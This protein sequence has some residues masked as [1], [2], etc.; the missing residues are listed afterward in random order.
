MTAKKIAKP[1]VKKTVPV[2][3]ATTTT[4]TKKVPKKKGTAPKKRG[5]PTKAESLQ[6]QLAAA[7]VIVAERKEL[8]ALQKQIA[9]DT[10]GSVVV[11]D[12]LPKYPVFIPGQRVSAEHC[13]IT[14]K[15]TVVFDNLES[16]MIRVQ[17]DDGSSQYAAKVNLQ[18]L[19]KKT[20]KKVFNHKK[21]MKEV[22]AKQ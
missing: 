16:A 9:A 1:R 17:W 22:K 13:G 19:V 10:T 3:K 6:K 7:A 11:P 8:I 15:G 21:A 12:S 20:L 4:T 18:V 2:V 5:R 14:Y